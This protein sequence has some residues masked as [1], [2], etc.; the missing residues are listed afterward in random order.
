MIVAQIGLD[1]QIFGNQG[2]HIEAI[3][4][5]HPIYVACGGKVHV[6]SHMP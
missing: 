5:S 6:K 4:H 2:N 3:T 1:G